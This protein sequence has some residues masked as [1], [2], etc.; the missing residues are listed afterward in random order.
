MKVFGV[1]NHVITFL[2]NVMYS[3]PSKGE[4]CIQNLSENRQSN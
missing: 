3:H 1:C 2:G 4:N